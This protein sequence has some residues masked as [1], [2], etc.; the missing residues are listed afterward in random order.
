[1]KRV[2]VLFGLLAL[3]VGH[4]AANENP[5]TVSGGIEASHYY[6]DSR[7]EVGE[8]S[9]DLSAGGYRFELAGGL[10]GQ[11]EKVGH[12]WYGSAQLITSPLPLGLRFGVGLA[13]RTWTNNIDEALSWPVNFSLSAGIDIERVRIQ[14][15]HLSNAGLHEPNWGESWILLGVKL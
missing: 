2:S 10:I 9:Y 8:L 4:A 15:R 1:M 6:S 3:S 14:L 7:T 11:Q 12:F 13:A 5:W